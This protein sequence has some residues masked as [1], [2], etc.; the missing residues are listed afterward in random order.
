M[1]RRCPSPST[2]TL[3]THVLDPC[4]TLRKKHLSLGFRFSPCKT[5]VRMP[6]PQ[7][8][9]ASCSEVTHVSHVIPH[10]PGRWYGNIVPGL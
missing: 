4:V 6:T 1:F 9:V 10:K 3:R 2:P 8:V 7:G 5:W